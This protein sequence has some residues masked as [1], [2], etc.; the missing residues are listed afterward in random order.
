MIPNPLTLAIIG[1]TAAFVVAL[2]AKRVIARQFCALCAA[3]SVTWIAMLALAYAG[4]I[5]DRTLIAL[6]VGQ[7]VTGVYYAA[8]T[9][10]PK[11]WTLFRLPFIVTLTV[12]AYSAVVATIVPSAM[13]VALALWLAFGIVYAMRNRAARVWF[14]RIVDCCRR[15]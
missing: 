6:L 7:S 12:I 4:A 2:A 11:R 13:L 14:A 1:I 9:R 10:V 3:V 15:W 5:T 8:E